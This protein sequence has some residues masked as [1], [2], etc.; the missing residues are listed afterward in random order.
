M[1]SLSSFPDP[2]PDP[3]QIKQYLRRKLLL[4]LKES[5]F[6]KVIISVERVKI[7]RVAITIDCGSSQRFI[8]SDTALIDWLDKPA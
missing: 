1:R 6:G 7:D 3:N 4:I 8:F 2:D 5:G